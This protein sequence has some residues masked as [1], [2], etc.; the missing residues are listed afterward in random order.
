MSTMRSFNFVFSASQ[1]RVAEQKNVIDPH[2]ERQL[3]CEVANAL[4]GGE[5]DEAVLEV[6]SFVPERDLPTASRSRKR[7]R[8]YA[9]PI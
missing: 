8:K 5:F 6:Y 2:L 7:Q 9:F 4:K 3:Y 1:S